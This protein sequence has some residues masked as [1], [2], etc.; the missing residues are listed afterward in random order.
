MRF[1]RQPGELAQRRGV[2]PGRDCL[3]SNH[4][5]VLLL[6]DARQ[7]EN[8]WPATGTTPERTETEEALTLFADWKPDTYNRLD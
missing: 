8:W 1:A 5:Q 2:Q 6:V 7:V 3:G 4:R